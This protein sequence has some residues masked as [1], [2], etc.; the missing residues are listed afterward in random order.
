MQSQVSKSLT[1]LFPAAVLLAG[2]A[3]LTG[4]VVAPYPGYTTYGNAYGGDGG[5][6]RC[7]CAHGPT[8]LTHRDHSRCTFSG[9]CLDWWLLGL[10][11]WSL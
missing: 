3:A 2:C 4:C 7:L 6:G 5:G 1:R 11:R 9:L 8:S 10:G